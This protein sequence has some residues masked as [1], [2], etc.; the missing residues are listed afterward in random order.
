MIAWLGVLGV[1]VYQSVAPI[2]GGNAERPMAGVV[3]PP[4]IQPDR[5]VTAPIV[6]ADSGFSGRLEIRSA[7][8][9]QVDAVLTRAIEQN[10]LSALVESDEAAD[11][12]IYKLAGSRQSVNRLVANLESIWPSFDAVTLHVEGRGR[13]VIPVSVEAV[14]PEQAASIVAQAST[15]A[16]MEV[17]RNC[18]VL[19]AVAR[20]MPGREIL[21]VVSDGAAIARDLVVIDDIVR[22]TGGRDA[23]L[24]LPQGEPNVNLTIV[25][26]RTK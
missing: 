1:V 3:E 7:M 14:T 11:A 24:T 15:E 13:R 4:R 22:P 21:A 17:A 10:G 12:R 20:N 8:A 18:A 23:T 25:L 2:P 16:S 5:P 19:N 6:V 9:A 26:L